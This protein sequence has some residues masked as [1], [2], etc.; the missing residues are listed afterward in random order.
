[1]YNIE[2]LLHL[3][4]AGDQTAKCNYLKYSHLLDVK[5]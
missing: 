1:M 5:I 2:C 4:L 3:L